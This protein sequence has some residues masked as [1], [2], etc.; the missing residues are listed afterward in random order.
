MKAPLNVETVVRQTKD[1]IYVH[2]TSYNPIR[3]A[4]TLPRLDRPIRPSLRMEEAMIFK[5]SIK[6]KKPFKSAMSASSLKLR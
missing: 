4:T 6:V 2:F 5:A 3:Q 1:K